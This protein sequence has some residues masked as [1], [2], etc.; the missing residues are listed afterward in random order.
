MPDFHPSLVVP[1]LAPRLG[2]H[3]SNAAGESLIARQVETK[4]H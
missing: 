3:V 1:P 2:I 4:P